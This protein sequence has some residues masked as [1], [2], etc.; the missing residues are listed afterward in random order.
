MNISL[1]S[2]LKHPI[3]ESARCLAGSQGMNRHLKRVSVFDC[4]FSKEE[5]YD[6]L[7]EEG[8]FFL[9]CLEQFDNNK[10][11][12]IEFLQQLI[13]RG[14]SGLCIVTNSEKPL[15]SEEEKQV[16][17]AHNFPVIAFTNNIPY[18][19]LLDVINKQIIHQQLNLI[20]E[21]KLEQ[22]LRSG[23]G[24][25]KLQLLY[26]INPHIKSY[27]CILLLTGPM[28]S[29]ISLAHV[30]KSFMNKEDD[31]F[32]EGQAY[33]LLVIS[34]TDS[35][36][37]ELKERLLTETITQNFREI[38]LGISQI[39][40]K[41]EINYALQEAQNA[42]MLSKLFEKPFIR[43]SPLSTLPLLVTLRDSH[44]LLAFYNSYVETLRIQASDNNLEEL[45]HTVEVYVD[46]GGDYKR[47]AEQIRQH[48]NTIR[49]RINK[50]KAYLNLEHDTIEFHQIIA[51]AVQA[52]KLLKQR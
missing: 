51:L 50:V 22:L 39:Y 37:L 10:G 7:I 14:S 48:E 2:I 42:L 28:N 21:Y 46:R 13:N 24:K 12:I 40:D 30:K 27:V 3:F 9:S 49:Y 32:I 38:H 31:L 11:Q 6:S 20:N 36:Q 47:A 25:E 35:K 33:R 26:N 16:C 43:Y 4:P 19:V 52:Q 5:S 29:A 34:S 1:E 44:E 18:A 8:D 41:R 17:E 45:L 23:D 15:L